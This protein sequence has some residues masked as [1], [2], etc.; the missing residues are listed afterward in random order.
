M[1]K[2]YVVSGMEYKLAQEIKQFLKDKRRKR[3][4]KESRKGN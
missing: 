4:E 1:K 2:V 3:N